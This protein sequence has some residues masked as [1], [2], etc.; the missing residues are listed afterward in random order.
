[1]CQQ[2]KTLKVFDVRGPTGQGLLRL[3]VR[4][5]VWRHNKHFTYNSMIVIKISVFSSSRPSP[6]ITSGRDVAGQLSLRVCGQGSAGQGVLCWSGSGCGFTGWLF[7]WNWYFIKICLHQN[8][9][10][11]W[12]FIRSRDMSGLA[13]QCLFYWSGSGCGF[14]GIFTYVFYQDLCLLL[15]LR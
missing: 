3:L 8:L 5:W 10:L 1:M 15:Q 6:V 4:G 12:L 2:V 13:G 9:G 7:T 11:V 14:T